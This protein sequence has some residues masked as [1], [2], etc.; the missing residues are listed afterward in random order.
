MIREN[1]MDVYSVAFANGEKFSLVA[2]NID[3]ARQ[4]A[5][6]LVPDHAIVA[7]SILGEVATGIEQCGAFN[8]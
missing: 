5:C 4:M 6:R 1:V 7:A 2:S 8:A 3:M